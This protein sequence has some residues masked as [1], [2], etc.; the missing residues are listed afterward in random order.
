M[1]EL[2]C[3]YHKKIQFRI[4]DTIDECISFNLFSEIKSL[5]NHLENNPNCRFV[6]EEK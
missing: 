5:E 2:K 6:G 3:V 1:I 4:P